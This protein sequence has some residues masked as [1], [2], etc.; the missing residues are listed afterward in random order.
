[1]AD[2]IL[3][4]S[5]LFGTQ[6]LKPDVFEDINVL[7]GR[8][9]AANF[10]DVYRHLMFDP[11]TVF[12][13][14]VYGST[15]DRNL[16]YVSASP[17]AIDEVVISTPIVISG[18]RQFITADIWFSFSVVSFTSATVF[19]ILYKSDNGT[20]FN[21]GAGGGTAYISNAGSV[22]RMS[23]GTLTHGLSF[24]SKAYFS[25]GVRGSF[26]PVSGGYNANVNLFGVKVWTFGT[27]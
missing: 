7:W 11:V 14:Y 1:M 21:I 4:G 24:G 9:I 16:S 27:Y 10:G 8:K 5:D 20:W 23:C 25:I 26:A 13:G 17:S 19:P 3:I 15:G 6:A 18:S 2:P 22:I 12:D